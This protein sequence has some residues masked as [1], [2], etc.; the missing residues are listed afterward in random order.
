VQSTLIAIGAKNIAIVGGSAAVSAPLASQLAEVAPVRRLAGADRFA[1]AVAVNEDAFKSAQTVLLATGRN[2]PDALTGA[3]WAGN[4]GLPLLESET[5]CVPVSS[6][7]GLAA[8]GAEHITELGGIA[9]LGESV[10]SLPR[11]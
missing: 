9:A 1:T 5:A 7:G 6:L 2:F 11:C 3:A 4:Q 10:D 8:L